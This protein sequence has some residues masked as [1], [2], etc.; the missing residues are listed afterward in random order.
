MASKKAKQRHY[1]R[2]NE[3]IDDQIIPNWYQTVFNSYSCNFWWSMITSN[4]TAYLES[5]L[6]LQEFV[7]TQ[8]NSEILVML[9]RT[10]FKISFLSS[11]TSIKFKRIK[12]FEQLEMNVY[13]YPT[14][15]NIVLIQMRDLWQNILNF[16]CWV[17]ST[18]NDCTPKK[19]DKLK[20]A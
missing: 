9:K 10:P 20:Q 1:Y 16:A 5:K 7:D 11:T 12:T 2:W 13:V 17:H 14:T 6:R 4:I 18:F 19:C 8:E 3:W 15:L